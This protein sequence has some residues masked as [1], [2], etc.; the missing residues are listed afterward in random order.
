MCN[1]EN[2]QKVNQNLEVQGGMY[3]LD[4][5]LVDDLLL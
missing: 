5:K 3:Q 1:I 4:E 2:S